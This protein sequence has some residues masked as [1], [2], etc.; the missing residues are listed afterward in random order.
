MFRRGTV[1]WIRYAG[2][3]GRIARESARTRSMK[4][5]EALLLKRKGEI[6]EGKCPVRLTRSY[7][8]QELAR[9]YATWASRQRFFKTKKYF[10]RQLAERF[11]NLPLNSFTSLAV[12]KYQ[13]EALKEVKPSTANR[14]V[15]CLKHMF[16]K[17]H[18]WGWVGDDTLK[19]VRGVKLL[20]EPPG[21]LRYLSQEECQALVETCTPH[22]RPIVLVALNTG[23]RL[24]EILGLRWEAVDLKHGFLLLDVTKNGERREIPINSTLRATLEAIPHGPES[25]YVFADRNGRPY[26]SVNNSFPTACKRAGIRDFRFHD[27]RHTFASHLIMAGVDLTTVKELL[28]HEDI[29]TTLRYSHLAP[30]HKVKAV[31]VLE[32]RLSSTEDKNIDVLHKN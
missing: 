30:S 6:A 9:E 14:R 25:E 10:I 4:Q 1:Y 13:T 3:D 18:E 11:G 32:E 26:K 7:T 29:E 8:F 27:L 5:A 23:M 31:S 24:G 21:R 22:L 15:T 20:E 16:T 17:A 2:P 12:E 28:G 19:R